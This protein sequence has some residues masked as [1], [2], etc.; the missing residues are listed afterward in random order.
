MLCAINGRATLAAR[1]ARSPLIVLRVKTF[2]VK[3]VNGIRLKN[4]A[5]MAAGQHI[6]MDCFLRNLFAVKINL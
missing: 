3:M 4:F 2:A 5:R 1:K 6:V